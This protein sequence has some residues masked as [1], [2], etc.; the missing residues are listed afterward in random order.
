MYGTIARMKVKPGALESLKGM[1]ERQPQGFIATYAY[2]LDSNPDELMVVVMFE[3]EVSDRANAGSP[4]QDREYRDLRSH[5]R[6]DPEW[7]DGEV[8]YELVKEKTTC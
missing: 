6:E 4:E 3:D 5:L 7:H 8:V 1:E 2:R